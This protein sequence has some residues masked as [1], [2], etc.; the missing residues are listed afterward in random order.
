MKRGDVYRV[1]MWPSWH[2]KDMYVQSSLWPL[3]LHYV[4]EIPNGRL[5]LP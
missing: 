1:L 4:T 5:S 3:V 2:I